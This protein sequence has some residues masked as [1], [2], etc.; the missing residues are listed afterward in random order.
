MMLEDEH[1]QRRR[2]IG[3]LSVLVDVRKKLRD[4]GLLFRGDGFDLGPKSAFEA[5]ARL[6]TVDDDGSFDDWRLHRGGPSTSVPFGANLR[7][8]RGGIVMSVAELDAPK[9]PL[10]Q[11]Y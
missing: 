1:P 3:R 4:R 7:L 10:A 6:V 5:N 2:K 8:I 11:V 9:T